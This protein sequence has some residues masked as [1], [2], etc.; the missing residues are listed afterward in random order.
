[1][2]ARALAA[3]TNFITTGPSRLVGAFLKPLIQQSTSIASSHDDII[4][5]F[6]NT[7]CDNS[8]KL[9]TFD[10]DQLYPSMPIDRTLAVVEQA[11]QRYYAGTRKYGVR[12]TVAMRFLRSIL[13]CQKVSCSLRIL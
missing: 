4:D 6:S 13:R 11:L 12:I 7:T 9:S 10:I 3:F 8:Y 5:W 1:M 2:S